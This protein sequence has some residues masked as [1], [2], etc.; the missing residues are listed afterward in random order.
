MA[1]SS[2]PVTRHVVADGRVTGVD[3]QAIVAEQA[4]QAGARAGE[5]AALRPMVTRVQAAVRAAYEA[6]AHEVGEIGTPTWR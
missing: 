6:R 4:A 1:S 2:T 3:E 5:V